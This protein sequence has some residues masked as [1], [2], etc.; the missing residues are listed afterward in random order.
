MLNCAFAY[1]SE[2]WVQTP[3]A[4]SN[5]PDQVCHMRI[6]QYNQ[7]RSPDE[8]KRDEEPLENIIGKAKEQAGEKNQLL[9]SRDDAPSRKPHDRER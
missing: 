3:M 2:E 5:E 9:E 7:E 8:A 1:N 6:S 4:Q